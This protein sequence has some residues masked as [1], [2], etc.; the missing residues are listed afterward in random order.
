M[1]TSEGVLWQVSFRVSPLC[2][3]GDCRDTILVALFWRAQPECSG[4]VGRGQLAAVPAVWRRSLAIAACHWR[5]A[6]F[7]IAMSHGCGSTSGPVFW[8]TEV[9]FSDTG[10]LCCRVD[11]TSTGEGA[12]SARGRCG[13]SLSRAL[14]VPSRAR[15]L[16]NR[17]AVF[18][19]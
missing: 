17:V 7:G 18:R 2:E 15:F 9:Q 4:F 13:A 8:S 11:A 16:V 5:R 6:W 3:V 14:P 12:P 19:R 10:L 1:V